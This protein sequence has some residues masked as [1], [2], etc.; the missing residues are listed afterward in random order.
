MTRMDFEWREGKGEERHESLW[1][2][3]W[4]IERAQVKMFENFNNLNAIG[5]EGDNFH[6]GVARGTKQGFYFINL[7]DEASAG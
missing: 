3:L 4:G 7:L 5:N 6:C 2:I 1:I